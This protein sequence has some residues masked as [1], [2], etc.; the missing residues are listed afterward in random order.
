MPTLTR[1]EPAD[2]EAIVRSVSLAF[3]GTPDGV[4]DWLTKQ[5]GVENLRVLRDAPGAPM[6]A[7]LLRIPMGQHYLGR[8]VPMVGIAGVAVPPERRG[9]GLALDLMRQSVRELADEGVP[10]SVLYASTQ[11]LYRQAG[12]EQAGILCRAS[13]LL[14]LIDVRERGLSVR[15]LT[16]EDEPALRACYNAQARHENGSLDRGPYVWA[17]IAEFRGEKHT[18]FGVFNPE[19]ALEGYLY[20]AQRR[21]P[22]SGRFAISL[23][24]VA[25]T[26]PRAGRRLLGV[27]S[28]FAM[29]GDDVLF[30]CG[31]LCPLLALLPQQRFDLRINQFWMLRVAC[32]PA[33]L[34]ARGYPRGLNARLT[35]DVADDVVDSNR[36]AWSFTVDN[37][38]ARAT[39]GAGSAPVL[40][41]DARALA[42]L[43]SG[44]RT[45]RQL[46]RL[47]MLA[48]DDDALD[49]A[50]AIFAA[51]TPGLGDFF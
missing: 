49:A 36:R 4:R 43:Y 29:M 16:P 11:T 22:E 20:L 7:S 33:A 40:H 34:E 25:F 30:Q 23:T 8:S 35:L 13:I 9:G 14:K 1:A 5:G 10:L 51:P 27:L 24:D 26:T 31:P 42:P 50:G 44:L 37:G 47:G 18:P 21:K 46:A 2:M 39:P 48:G 19:G 15:E 12:F 32:L 38:R 17:R 6:L 28:D 45:P 3:A 41:L